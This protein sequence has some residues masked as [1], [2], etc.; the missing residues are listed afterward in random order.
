[1]TF[2]KIGPYPDARRP[3]CCIACDRLSSWLLDNPNLVLRFCRRRHSRI[4][5]FGLVGAYILAAVAGFWLSYLFVI[6]PLLRS[7]KDSHDI[8]LSYDPDGIRAD[9]PKRQTLYKWTTIERTFRAGPRLFVLIN[10]QYGLVVSER[11]TTSENIDA[12]DATVKQHI[13]GS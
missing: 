2:E 13:S 4:D 7:L 3:T 9:T 5:I 6:R 10:G 1:M 12:L 11:F 8:W